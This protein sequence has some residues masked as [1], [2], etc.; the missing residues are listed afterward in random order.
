[1]GQIYGILNVSYVVSSLSKI[2]I[3]SLAKNKNSN[4][5]EWD[6]LKLIT[7]GEERD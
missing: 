4:Y 7:Q 6:L 1:M 5:L 3:P 2:V